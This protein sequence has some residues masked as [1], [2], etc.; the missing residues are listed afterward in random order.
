MEEENDRDRLTDG[1][2]WS[3]VE[4]EMNPEQQRFTGQGKELNDTSTEASKQTEHGVP[5]YPKRHGHICFS[6]STCIL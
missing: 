6:V 5:L 3:L 2:K 4:T 1:G